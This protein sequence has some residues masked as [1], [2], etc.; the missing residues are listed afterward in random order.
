VSNAVRREKTREEQGLK[1]LDKVVVRTIEELKSFRQRALEA[2]R[3]SAELEALLKSFESGKETLGSMK[4]RL[5][6]LEDENRD[7]RL[8]V[9][10]GRETVERMLA[11]IGFLE[12]QK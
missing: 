9:G 8:R 10:H 5:T 2:E 11:R 6:R 3:R 4:Q 1:A 12:D 7:L